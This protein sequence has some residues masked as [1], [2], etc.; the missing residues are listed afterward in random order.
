ML[1][2]YMSFTHLHVHSHYSLLDGLPKINEL[3]DHAK[4]Q[5]FSHL[6]LTDHGV[7][8]GAIEFYETC[9]QAGIQPII[10]AEV[11]V[12][13]RTR[14]D[15]QPR[16]D[17]KPYHLIL[18]AETLEGYYNLIKL[19]SQAH[20]EGYYYR[21]RVDLDLLQQHHTGL[22]ALSS[23]LSGPISR[24]ILQQ[25]IPHAQAVIE[26]YQH[27][28]GRDSFFLE[29]QRHANTP[30]QQTVNSALLDLAKLTQ[31]PLVATADSHYLKPTDAEA[32]DILVC[33]QTKKSVSDTARLSMRHD[34]FSLG[35]AAEMQQLFAD[36]PEAL[37][38]TQRIAERC[39]VEIPLGVIQLPHYA[40]PP[41]KTDN[42]VLRELCLSNIPKHYGPELAKA[43][44]ERLDYELDVIRK[45]G[46]ASYFLIVQDFV[47]WSRSQHIVVGPG[48]GS[49]A[50]SIVAYLAG[51]TQ[52]DPLKYDLLFER[53]LN[54]ERVSMPDIDLD[55][56][57]TRRDEV[58]RYVESKYGKDHVAQIIT[59]GTM[60]ARAAVRDVGRALGLTYG[61]CDMIAKLIP[62]FSSL[63]EALETVPELQQL[64][65]SD[66]DA[67][68][69]IDSAL[70]LEGVVRHTST[71]ACGVIITK[72]PLQHYTPVQYSSTGEN[73][74]VTQYSLHP[75]ESLGLLKMDFLGLK[76]LTIIEQTLELITKTTDEVIDIDALPLTDKPT[77]R[78]LQKAH[79]TGIFQLESAGMKRYLR[80]LKPT[81]FDDIIAMVALY[82]PGPMERI[83]DYIAGKHHKRPVTYLLESLKPIL[84]KTY[85]IL[86]YQEQVMAMARDIAGF[87][88]GEGYL[89]IKAVG[90][91]IERLLNEQKDKFIQ[92]AI[93][94]KVSKRVAEQLWEFIEPFAHYGF[95]K[96]HSTGYALIA[97]QTAYLKAN[98]PAQFMASLLTSDRDDSDRIAIEVQE[99]RALGIAVL[100]P[101]INESYSTFTVVR[102]SLPAE[103]RIRFGLAAVKQVGQNLVT[104]IIAERKANGPFTD[105]E[106]FLQR[107]QHR[108]LNKKSL[109]SLIMCGAMAALGDAST[110]LANIETL[111]QYNKTAQQERSSGQSSLFGGG[112]LAAPKLYLATAPVV[113]KRVQLEWERTLLGLYV[114]EHPLKRMQ[115][116]TLPGM[117]TI[118][119]AKELRSNSPI[120]CLGLVQQLRRVYT[121][122][123][124]IMQ[125]F[126]FGD[127]SEQIEVVLFAR[128][129]QNLKT[130]LSDGQCVSVKGKISKRDGEMK[131]I[132]E[133]VTAW[134]DQF[135]CLQ[136]PDTTK[137]AQMTELKQTLE[138]HVGDL[139]LYILA[140]GKLMKTQ[141]LVAP[142]VVPA[143]AEQLGQDR[144][145]LV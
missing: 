87:T 72:E 79:T 21:P 134:P 96:S 20:L 101:D 83:P 89:L 77:Y 26:R 119:E 136:L 58:I 10:G 31:A 98:Y 143:L 9:K 80:E 99:A 95:N 76:N 85:G 44:E 32:Q 7:L 126:Q 34:D 1:P 137:T 2:Q 49:A 100:P 116:L 86:V 57:D 97:Y 11:Y 4:E 124:D 117:V 140:K 38:N 6:A 63:Q 81:E 88:A 93:K 92:G 17:D 90:K 52:I 118:A 142:T 71:H 16:V 28:F 129:M 70:K 42:E 75:I 51:I 43:A 108:D 5:G 15:R 102:E 74:I 103:P 120:Q 12:A 91:K 68:R 47:N 14:F 131:I 29:L 84:E 133:E 27:I 53:F 112:M 61:F 3:V 41:G 39:R 36:V 123:G 25:D 130:V 138:Q 94:N 48:R 55:F 50:G 128:A 18:L 30:E 24:A 82:R 73:D 135:L 121:K 109:E 65:N 46:Y 115:A 8:Y 114:S 106:N 113:S 78:L 64:Y 104:A 69:L 125:F 67:T 139:P 37:A 127:A 111:L 13:Q 141:S 105:I 56:A 60:A 132:A 23:C 35:S 110:L 66:A 40:L 45:T 122:T 19:V 59:F 54:P 62:M 22:I 33:I 144:V 107:I 145:I